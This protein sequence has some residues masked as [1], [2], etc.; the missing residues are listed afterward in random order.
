MPIIAGRVMILA[1]WV[2]SLA[3]IVAAAPMQGRR[4]AKSRRGISDLNN[5][6]LATTASRPAAE[7][8]SVAT[9]LRRNLASRNRTSAPIENSKIR[10][11]IRKKAAS[12]STLATTIE[13]KKEAIAATAMTGNMRPVLHAKTMKTGQN[14]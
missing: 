2:L 12:G 5:S 6:T 8:A 13:R 4:Y 11:G 7:R 9:L 1:A 3:Q 10:N 14:R